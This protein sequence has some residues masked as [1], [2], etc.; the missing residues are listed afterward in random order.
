MTYQQNLLLAISLIGFLAVSTVSVKHSGLWRPYLALISGLLVFG[1]F[2]H[3]LFGFPQ[4]RPE[5]AAKGDSGQPL[6]VTTA[7]YLCMV[8]G[9]LAQHLYFH[10][11][12]GKTSRPK[13]D[14]GIFLSPVLAS[15]IVFIPLQG[16]LQSAGIDLMAQPQPRI[17][18]FLVAFEN[19]FF[20][21][22]FFDRQR[23]EAVKNVESESIGSD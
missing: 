6:V 15:P 19:G 5:V 12:R 10:F 23:R 18:L 3:Q 22:D 11:M 14:W 17:M 13:W 4:L 2:L 9:M 20:W 8:T 16:A 1:F 7:L 21:K